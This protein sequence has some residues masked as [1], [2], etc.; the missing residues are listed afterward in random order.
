MTR[1]QHYGEWKTGR[2]LAWPACSSPAAKVRGQ[3]TSRSA[4]QTMPDAPRRQRNG[5]SSQEKRPGRITTS[6]TKLPE[7][8]EHPR[9][10]QS[11]STPRGISGCVGRDLDLT[12][13][14]WLAEGT[15]GIELYGNP[16]IGLISLAC[17]KRPSERC[18]QYRIVGVEQ[19]HSLTVRAI[20]DVP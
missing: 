3:L 20:K 2:E 11:W 17:E 6:P 16:V 4:V 18:S 10:Q 8:A 19:E 5:G 7:R 1:S 14:R 9:T 13:P 12:A 15:V